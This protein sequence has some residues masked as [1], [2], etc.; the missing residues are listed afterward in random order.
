M[1]VA[2]IS[3]FNRYDKNEIY[4]QPGVQTDYFLYNYLSESTA[5]ID[6]II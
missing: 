2:I 5:T 4:Q 1:V 6:Y 3:H